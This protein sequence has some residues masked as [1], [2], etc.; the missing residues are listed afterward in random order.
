MGG[1]DRSRC[2][3]RRKNHPAQHIHCTALA[4]AIRAMAC[5][6]LDRAVYVARTICAMVFEAQTDHREGGSTRG[7]GGV[8]GVG[9]S[10]CMLR[11]D[12]PRCSEHAG[13]AGAAARWWFRSKAAAVGRDA[14]LGGGERSE[15]VIVRGKNGGCFFKK[16]R[17]TGRLSAAWHLVRAN[18]YS[19]ADENCTCHII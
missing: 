12:G 19:S 15:G 16:S 7:R 17:P 3:A 10:R 13:A 4:L 1:L 11:C 18:R 9:K 6:V 8:P 14:R 5:R 2:E